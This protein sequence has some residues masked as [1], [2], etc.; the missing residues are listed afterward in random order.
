MKVVFFTGAG[1]SQES[2]I[3]TFRDSDGTWEEYNVMDVAHIDK[4]KSKQN[5]DTNRQYML[6]FYNKRRAQMPTVFPNDAH[7]STATI[8]YVHIQ[9]PAYQTD[10]N[11]SIK[12]YFIDIKSTYNI[13]EIKNGMDSK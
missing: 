13:S 11:I 1:I 12:S 6:D 5:R 10:R 7:D 4:W 2:G 9:N 3:K 8:N